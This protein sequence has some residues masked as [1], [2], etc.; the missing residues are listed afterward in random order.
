MDAFHSPK[1][2]PLATLGVGLQINEHLAC[3]PPKEK[4][5]I[6]NAVEVKSAFIR[7]LPGYNVKFLEKTVE[8]SAGLQ[9]VILEMPNSNPMQYIQ[10]ELRSVLKKMV[11]AN[12]CVILGSQ[13]PMGRL[14]ASTSD[15]SKDLR[16][17]GVAF[18]GDMTMEAIAT[19]LAYT[20]GRDLSID[21]I[22]RIMQTNIRG[23][24]TT[25]INH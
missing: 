19:K 16:D 8:R 12:L 7:I 22:R 5:E 23:E 3:N 25:G 24:L 10:P 1:F 4:F 14:T 18:S 17:L 13:C 2:P 9:A 6:R 15:E 21:N 11:D 20:Y